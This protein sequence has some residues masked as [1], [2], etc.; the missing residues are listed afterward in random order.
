ML[1][2]CMMA[3]LPKGAK[4]GRRGNKVMKKKCSVGTK[5]VKLRKMSR[6]TKNKSTLCGVTPIFGLIDLHV[7]Y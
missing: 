4:S 1:L 3:A 6:I 5:A 7:N 2:M